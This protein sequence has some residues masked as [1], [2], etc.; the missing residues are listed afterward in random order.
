MIDPAVLKAHNVSAED[1]KP[2][3][4]GEV[5]EGGPKRLID[6]ASERVRAGLLKN[7]GDAR[8]WWAIDK[9]Y[10]VPFYQTSYTLLRGLLDRKLSNEEVLSACNEF[11][12]THL[13]V[14]LPCTTH[15]D[16]P[17][18]C[19]KQ[20]KLDLPVFFQVLIPLVQAYVKIRWAKIYNDHDVYPVFKFEP[21]KL[22]AKNRLR[23]EILTDR[24]QL[25][26]AQYGYG[27]VKRQII[28]Q[29][30]LYSICLQFPMECWHQEK[31]LV[32]EDDKYEETVV[33]EGLRYQLPHPSRTFFDP[34]HRP[35]TLNSDS[36]C[37]FAG[38]WAIQPYGDIYD[39][40]A[41]W[42]KDKVT[43]GGTNWMFSSDFTAP[44]GLYSQLYP[45]TLSFP[46]VNNSNLDRESQQYFY[47]SSE[48]DKATINVEMFMK[49]A[50][51]QYGLADYDYP[52]WH[53]LVMANDSTLLY[54]E[55]LAYSPTIYYGYDADG[56]RSMNA[57]MG[58]EI[59]PFQDLVGQYL[60]QYL[61]SVKK[62][63]RNVVFY[64]PALVDQTQ[65]AKLKN[66]GDKI[67]TDTQ[68]LPASKMETGWMQ[69]SA[70]E[71]FWPVTFPQQN[72]TE[73]I[74]VVRSII[75]I[76]ERVLVFS[77]QEIGQAASHEQSAHEVGVISQNTG[78]RVSFTASFTEDG[79][80][81]WKRQLYDAHMAYSDDEIF[82]QVANL[83]A[84][85]RKALEDLGFKIEEEPSL[86][87]T[88]AGVIGS[89]SAL[90]M[91]GIASTRDGVNR[92]NTPAI[93]ATMVQLVQSLVSIPNIVETVGMKQIVDWYN[94]I[95]LLA[96]MP[97]D[98]K[99]TVKNE[100]SPEQQVNDVKEQLTAIQQQVGEVAQQVVN[101]NMEQLAGTLKKSL[102]DPMQE[103]MAQLVK[104][105]QEQT[106]ALVQQQ[107]AIAKLD[108][109]V[110]LLAKAPPLQPPL[111]DVY[112]Q[113]AANLPVGIGQPPGM[114]PGP[115]LE[116]VGPV[117]PI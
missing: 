105:D 74:N 108:Q 51:S 45:C 93:A 53:R 96:G 112:S 40:P 77:A 59:M 24:I 84:T 99:I 117:G 65:L 70:R 30:L 8:L 111:P 47:T 42:N 20:K 116:P 29:Q 72:T 55:P 113:P 83:N 54:C 66:L 104:S 23:S 86:G 87:E 27:A 11:G 64:D 80:H 109:I 28:F 15:K 106:Q 95:A 62:N 3:F 85:N 16:E 22:T 90:V 81:A 44:W 34:S 32:K 19:V 41:Y 14:D 33:K 76:L 7:L 107:E 49:F 57:G 92:I 100:I 4:T 91:D 43:Y 36:G 79:F 13:L 94:Q 101:Q 71:A 102:I 18:N 68:F 73:I 69:T 39:N 17:C 1:Y 103:G 78:N 56:N 82:A 114:A 12:L 89:K 5:I 61:L 50:P 115:V 10:D 6:L 38:Y 2:K 25:T 9:G 67:F 31:Q 37:R 58:I 21:L 98:F 46:A 60:S 35:D 97:Q 75:E 88:H 48:Q 26:A 52:V 63:L 110:E